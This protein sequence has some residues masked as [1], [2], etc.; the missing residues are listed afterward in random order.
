MLRSLS[1]LATTKVMDVQV[2]CDCSK[3]IQQVPSKQMSIAS[4][5]TQ[6]VVEFPLYAELWATVTL[7][8]LGE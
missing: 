2:E 5:P 3:G 8:C 6:A 4:K 1:L 7:Q